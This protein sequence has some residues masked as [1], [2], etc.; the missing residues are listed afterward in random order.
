MARKLVKCRRERDG[1]IIIEPRP[2]K[3]RAPSANEE[4]KLQ[5]ECNLW[6]IN[7]WRQHP[8]NLWTTFNEGKN[9]S[10]RLSMGMV[11]GVSDRLYYESWGRGL[12]GLEFKYPGTKHDVQHVIRQCEWILEVCDGGGF[13]DDRS[14]FINIITGHNSWHD[15][16]RVLL[17]L[18]KI[19]TSSFIWDG[20]KF[21]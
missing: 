12:I 18:S 21:L 8:K 15:P 16:S 17:Y 6:Y 7:E 19:K 2:P 11:S 9:V 13:I 20:S 5:T 14:Q 10:Q 4:A 3:K 1:M